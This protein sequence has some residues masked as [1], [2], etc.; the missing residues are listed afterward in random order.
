MEFINKISMK[1]RSR[2]AKVYEKNLVAVIG[3][4]VFGNLYDIDE[5]ILKDIKMIRDTVIEAARI[6]NLHIIEIMEKQF[7][8]QNSPDLGGVSMI[9]LIEESHISLHTWPESR[10]ATVDIYS[11]GG[12]SN[13]GLA[14]DYI[15]SVMKPKSYK[16]FTADRGTQNG[17]EDNRVFN[18]LD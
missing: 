13:P 12:G 10:Y 1:R 15:V 18:Q 17:Q 7:N 11:C 3:K 6:G 2:S 16:V 5:K 14:F 8:V 9:A 4:H